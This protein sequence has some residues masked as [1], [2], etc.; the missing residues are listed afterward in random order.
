MEVNDRFVIIG[1]YNYMPINVEAPNL[2]TSNNSNHLMVLNT[3]FFL[4]FG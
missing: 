1:D 3:V 2:A 4:T